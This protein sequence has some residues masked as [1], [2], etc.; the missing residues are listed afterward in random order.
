MVNVITV[1]VATREANR[2]ALILEKLV[3]NAVERT[4]S[5]LCVDAVRDQDLSQNVNQEN[6]GQI[7]PAVKDVYTDV[8]YMRLMKSVRMTQAWRTWLT[9]F[10]HCFISRKYWE[11]LRVIKV[12]VRAH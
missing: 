1:D 10:S 12:Y 9:K 5:K 8:M 11:V 7:G 3:I 2:I 4:T 6:I